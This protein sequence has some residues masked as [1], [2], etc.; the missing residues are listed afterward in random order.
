[1]IESWLEIVSTTFGVKSFENNFNKSYIF[2]W[3][4][5]LLK[6]QFYKRDF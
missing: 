5:N 6:Y 4:S 2:D 3:L 1:M